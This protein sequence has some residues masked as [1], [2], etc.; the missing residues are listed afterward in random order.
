MN[1]INMNRTVSVRS[2]MLE[3]ISKSET[4]ARW[5]LTATF[6][7]FLIGNLPFKKPMYAL[8]LVA[9]LA[10]SISNL[11]VL[12]KIIGGSLSLMLLW[13]LVIASYF[14]SLVPSASLEAILSQSIFLILALCIVAHHHSIG[15]SRSLRSAAM[16]LIC[17]V[18]LYCLLFPG[19]ALS[20]SGL[21]AFFA[22]KNLLGALM[23]LCALA[24]FHAPLRTKL[25]M[26][27]GLI[28]VVLMVAS[29]SK[30]SISLF[31]LC[32]VL[33]VMA[34]WWSAHFYKTSEKLLLTDV[35][36]GSLWLSGLLGLG[37]FVFFS[38]ELFDFF[39]AIL[40]KTAFTGRG[41]LWL[42]V[43]QQLRAHTLLGIGPG[44][45][46]QAGGA[47]EI[48]QTTLFQKSPYWVQHMVSSDGSYIDIMASF[49]FI[50][51]ALFFLTAADLYRRLFKNWQRVESRIIFLMATFIILHATTESTILYST[52]ILWLIY[53]ICYLT[54]TAYANHDKL[55]DVVNVKWNV[56]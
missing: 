30:T 2:S 24:L 31:L 14:W 1:T 47:S 27:F 34:N 55:H 45:V 56:K 48:I 36:R 8:V 9:Y 52:N 6:L 22:Q 4:V 20:A 41:A 28:A 3:R 13:G 21:K 38:N 50:G 12:A 42:A 26:A 29:L 35:I 23:A 10:L 40:P 11:K 17:F 46:W 39:W 37:L 18:V 25:H 54:V 51:L 49:G 44:T 15:F 5:L 19:S 53:L 32:H 16:A 43:L 7:V 33:L